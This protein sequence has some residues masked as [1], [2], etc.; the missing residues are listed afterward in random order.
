MHD[1]ED[2]RIRY[3]NAWLEMFGVPALYTPYISHPDPTVDRASGF[4]SPTI[5]VSETF[6]GIAQ[7]PYY[8]AIS[9]TMDAT[10]EPI[11]TTKQG[12]VLAGEYRQLLPFGMHEF[13][14]S[15]TF[16]DRE[17]KDGSI[18]KDVLRGHV[19]A[20]GQYEISNTWRTGFLRRVRLGTRTC[21]GKASATGSGA[22]C[23]KSGNC[24]GGEAG[25]KRSLLAPKISRLSWLSSCS[26]Q[27]SF[28]R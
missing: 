15:G 11:F 21:S 13:E 18:S 14:G 20:K 12:V 25:T 22:A 6:G 3:R 17:E 16:A 1:E 8:W 2:H 19:K 10:F 23:L 9:P 4:L 24:S 26:R 28:S 7:F 27:A 5:G